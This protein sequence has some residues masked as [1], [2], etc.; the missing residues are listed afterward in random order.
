MAIDLVFRGE[1]HIS[2]LSIVAAATMALSVP[3]LKALL[4]LLLRSL[5]W[6]RTGQRASLRRLILDQCDAGVST[7]PGSACSPLGR[8][9]PSWSV[10]PGEHGGQCNAGAANIRYSWGGLLFPHTATLW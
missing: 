4:H 1:P 3:T 10:S 7:L 9:T 2:R 8:L 5:D 6:W